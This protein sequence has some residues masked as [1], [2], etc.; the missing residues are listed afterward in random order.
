LDRVQY[1]DPGSAHRQ[2]AIL[3]ANPIDSDLFS[4][5]ISTAGVEWQLT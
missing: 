5:S 3:S 2:Y 1:S 4:E